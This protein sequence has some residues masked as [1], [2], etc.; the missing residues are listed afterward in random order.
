MWELLTIEIPWNPNIATIGGIVLT[1]HGLFTAVGILVGVQVALRIA[2]VIG[3]D[4]DELYT[5]AL[6]AVPA[7]I[8][9]ARGLFVIEN[10]EFF[11][12]NIS[13]IIALNEG[14]I[15]V[16][17]SLVTGVL[18]A[19]AWSLWRHYD[20][21][22]QLDVAAF[23]VIIGLGIGRIGDLINGEHLAKKSDLPWSVIY[24]DPHSP[25]FAHSIAIGPHHPAT[26]YELLFAGIIFCVLFPLF[27]RWLW[28]YPGTTFV[29]AAALYALTRFLLT[30]LRLDSAEALF[31]FRVPQL[32]AV[33]TLLAVTPLGMYWFRR[34][35]SGE[36]YDQRLSR[37][38]SSAEVER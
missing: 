24:T 21:R 2:R 22:A 27:F 30:Y 11:G 29:V 15:S 38:T 33:L 18:G 36:K 37:R 1:W 10:W 4:E 34:G 17:G 7:G 3:L 16:W 13:D 8:V 12:D 14:G 6:V 20:V 19:T 35:G 31:G 26:T 9:G 32:M 5:L 25:A 28:R 23:G